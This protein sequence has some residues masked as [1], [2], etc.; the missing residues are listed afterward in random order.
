MEVTFIDS[1]KLRSTDVTVSRTEQQK[2]DCLM[3]S[4]LKS[5]LAETSS[6]ISVSFKKTVLI[7]SYE[8]EVIEGST[9]ITLDRNISGAERAL[10]IA[11]AEI[12]IEY[13]AYTNL[14]MKGMITQSDF[15]DRKAQ[16][17]NNVLALKQKAESIL[18]KS[19][20]EYVNFSE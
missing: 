7:R 1:S 3:N 6:I 20:D 11:I 2:T 15:F 18:G 19:M 14:L 9:Q 16:L 12:Q 17:V 5:N 13:E 8:T 4:I 10:I